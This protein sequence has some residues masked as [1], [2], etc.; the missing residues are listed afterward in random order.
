M[1]ASEASTLNLPERKRLFHIL[2]DNLAY[3]RPEYTTR[4]VILCPICLREL[5]IEE[6]GSVE[7]I[8]ARNQL[9]N[10]PSYMKEISLSRRAG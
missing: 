3:E 6:L 8:V 5:S 10:D 4:E 7:H 1:G 2:H 9:E